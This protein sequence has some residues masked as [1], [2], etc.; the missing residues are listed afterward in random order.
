MCLMNCILYLEI[1]KKKFHV[2][3]LIFYFFLFFSF[4]SNYLQF[5]LLRLMMFLSILI[6]PVN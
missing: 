2:F 5:T 6:I 1:Y 4:L 3:C